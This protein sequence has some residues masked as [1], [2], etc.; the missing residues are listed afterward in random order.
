MIIVDTYQGLET[1]NPTVKAGT[2][3]LNFYSET[4]TYNRDNKPCVD[5]TIP[6]ELI[7]QIDTIMKEV[8]E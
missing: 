5:F 1:I 7:E 4:K 2:E 8:T 3:R 6:N